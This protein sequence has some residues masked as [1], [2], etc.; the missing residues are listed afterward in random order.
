[1]AIRKRN[2][3]VNGEKVERFDGLSGQS[4]AHQIT[5]VPPKFTD[6]ELKTFRDEAL[7]VLDLLDNGGINIYDENNYPGMYLKSETNT[8]RKIK[9]LF[10][11]TPTAVNK[12]VNNVSNKSTNKDNSGS[13]AK[14]ENN[15]DLNNL[16]NFFKRKANK[17]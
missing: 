16:F 7:E 5:D 14:E 6:I 12:V 1:M 4:T 10:T 15:Q 17:I 11:D 8:N 9:S 13:E 2:R 3:V